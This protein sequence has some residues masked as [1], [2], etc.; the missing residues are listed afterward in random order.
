LFEKNMSEKIIKDITPE[1][2]HELI[3]ENKDNADFV[4]IDVRTK[5]EYDMGHID[6]ASLIDIYRDDFKEEMDKLDRNKEYLVYC[7]TGARS[8]A[9]LGMM[10]EM[11]FKKAYNMLYGIISYS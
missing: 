5:M 4:I 6:N 8:A 10:D 11:D 7:R 2:A 9:A 1:E 3:L